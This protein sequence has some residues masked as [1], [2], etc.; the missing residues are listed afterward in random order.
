MS[1][2]LTS[3]FT[4]D[5]KG[6]EQQQ[7]DTK[8]E[9]ER[10]ACGSSDED[11]GELSSPLESPTKKS[12]VAAME[13]DSKLGAE[14]AI[15]A[16][17]TM[18]STRPEDGSSKSSMSEEFA[19]ISR[20]ELVAS[21]FRQPPVDANN[22]WNDEMDDMLELRLANPISDD[23]ESDHHGEDCRVY[24]SQQGK[25]DHPSAHDSLTRELI[26][27]KVSGEPISWSNRLQEDED[28]GFN[29]HVDQ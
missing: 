20:S 25:A 21:V 9:R 10:T 4:R 3:I 13:E 16:V 19:A 27:E 11:G 29:I 24:G 28:I 6:R 2:I 26:D 1:R 7:R 17:A 12:R 18:P 23:D 14:D 22:F 15:A 8:N 5:C